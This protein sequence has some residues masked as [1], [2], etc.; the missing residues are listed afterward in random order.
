MTVLGKRVVVREDAL[1][2]KVGRLYVPRTAKPATAML[3]HTGIVMGVGNKVDR[4]QG[5][6]QGANV[7][8]GP[9]GLHGGQGR[10]MPGDAAGFCHSGVGMTARQLI[11]ELKKVP[12]DVEVYFSDDGD[13]I[14]VSSVEYWEEDEQIRIG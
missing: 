8:A 14:E 4:G 2:D 10:E 11:E 9:H 1:P 7:S 6:R 5:W 3:P 12:L 13:T